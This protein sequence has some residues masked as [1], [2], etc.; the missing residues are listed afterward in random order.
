[1]NELSVN[2]A[3]ANEPYDRKRVVAMLDAFCQKRECFNIDKYSFYEPI[4]LPFSREV[5]SE[6]VAH[7]TAIFMK[8]SKR[9]IDASICAGSYVEL[10]C[11]HSKKWKNALAEELYGLIQEIAA[12]IEVDF[13]FCDILTDYV[14]QRGKTIDAVGMTNRKK[15]VYDYTLFKQTLVHGFPDAFHYMLINKKLLR[16]TTTLTEDLKDLY[17]VHENDTYVTLILQD[18]LGASVS[19]VK[20][21]KAYTILKAN[22]LPE[23][24][25]KLGAAD[26]TNYTWGELVSKSDPLQQAIADT[27]GVIVVYDPKTKT[28]V[29][30]K[31]R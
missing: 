4:K 2:I 15:E 3:T 16:D 18:E 11:L 25:E 22:F 6:I 30:W 20:K 8:D 19:S 26:K 17:T 23:K 31:P 24:W 5:I 7:D 29:D 14:V 28:F 27:S 1:M 12:H 13:A 10:I 9:H 21:K